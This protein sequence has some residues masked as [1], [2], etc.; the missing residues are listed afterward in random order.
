MPSVVVKL[1]A[2]L[3]FEDDYFERLLQAFEDDPALGIASGLCHELQDDAWTPIYGTRSH[4]WGAARAYRRECLP[5]VMPLE[6]REGWDEIDALKARLAGWE[7]RLVP[8]LPFR[9]HRAMGQRDGLRRVWLA[10]GET[11]HYMGYRPLYLLVRTLYRL[12]REPEAAL[13]LWSFAGAVFHRAPRLSDERVR[14]YLREQQR[15]RSLPRRAR[16]AR[17]QIV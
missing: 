1:D 17:G 8:D 12:R 13:M 11:A 10:Q 2:D 4:V 6:E 5:V 7:T 15:L 16:E 14:S 3:T 9:H